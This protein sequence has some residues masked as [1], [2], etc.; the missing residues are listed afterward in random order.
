MNVH[1]SKV[2]TAFSG[3]EGLT[4]Q[5][6]EHRFKCGARLKTVVSFGPEGLAL[7]LRGDQCPLLLQRLLI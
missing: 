2:G 6:Q 3:G 7:F 1:L 4:G 5:L